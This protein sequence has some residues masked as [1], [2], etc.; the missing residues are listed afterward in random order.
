MSDP[1]TI[2]VADALVDDSPN[3]EFVAV[4][5]PDDVTEPVELLKTPATALALIVEELSTSVP[6]DPL[7]IPYPPPVAAPV[8]V[9]P[10]VVIVPVLV[11]VTP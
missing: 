3:A 8:I 6:V 9:Q 4:I 5:S 1:L 7:Y 11:F 2:T 10:V